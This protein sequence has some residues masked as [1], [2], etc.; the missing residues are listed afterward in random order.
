[1]VSKEME[2]IIEMLKEFQASTKEIS[3][4]LMRSGLDEMASM[5]TIPEHACI[6]TLL[7]MFGD[8]KCLIV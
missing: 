5:V 1:M 7:L 2:S 6:I 3:V 4:E 8:L